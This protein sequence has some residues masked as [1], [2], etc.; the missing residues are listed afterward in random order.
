MLLGMLVTT[1]A[2]SARQF[3]V[4]RGLLDGTWVGPLA[5]ADAVKSGR[6]VDRYHIETTPGATPA[7]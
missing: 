6:H 5:G 1:V 7:T 2:R 3:A 4:V